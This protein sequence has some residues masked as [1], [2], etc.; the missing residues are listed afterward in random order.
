MNRLTGKTAF[1]TGGGTWIGKAIAKLFALEGA[2]VFLVARDEKRLITTKQEIEANGGIVDYA[3]ADVSKESEV[4]LATTKAI[5]TFGEIDIFV[6]NAGIYPSAMLNDM[7]L[8]EWRHVLDV[9][10]TGTFI[11]LK[12]LANHIKKLA[13]SRIIFISSIAGEQMGF[14]GYAHY[15]ASKAGMNGFMRTAALE[16]AQHNITVNSI[17]PGNIFNDAVSTASATEMD[18]MLK[19]IPLG[20]IGKPIDVANLA[21]FLASDE[22]SFITGQNFIIDGGE[23]IS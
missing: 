11:T 18:A 3:V 14:R 2:N 19:A 17:D 1:I 10:L 5:A 4:E 21:L 7:T 8:A 12:A 20:R 22:S 6:Q 15:T 16:F 23:T 9:N 13:N